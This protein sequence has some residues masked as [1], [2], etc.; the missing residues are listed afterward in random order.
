MESSTFG[1][2]TNL[3]GSYLVS[4]P[5]PAHRR[6]IGVEKRDKSQIEAIQK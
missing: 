2:L 1:T 5:T 6:L 4:C 3:T